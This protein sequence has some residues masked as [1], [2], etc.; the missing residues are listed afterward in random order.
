MMNALLQSLIFGAA[1]GDVA[2]PVDEPAPGSDCADYPP[3]LAC[4][5][6]QSSVCL[7]CRPH[8]VPGSM[9]DMNTWDAVE[10][11]NCR[12]PESTG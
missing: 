3:F 11:E 4:P 2:C 8:P 10:G 6:E 12:Q 9:Y 7:K 1:I 5:Y